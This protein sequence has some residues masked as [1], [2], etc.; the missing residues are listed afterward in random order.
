MVYSMINGDDPLVYLYFY[1]LLNLSSR[2]SRRLSQ[3]S[4]SVKKGSIA[5]LGRSFVSSYIAEAIVNELDKFGERG[6]Y[7][8]IKSL[9]LWLRG[10]KSRINPFDSQRVNPKTYW[11]WQDEDPSNSRCM[12][13]DIFH[14]VPLIY[15]IHVGSRQALSINKLLARLS[16]RS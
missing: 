6:C 1:V 4:I 2:K 5:K 16:Y 8:L 7:E 13:R 10:A 3:I 14:E 15:A 9:P 11:Q 12:A